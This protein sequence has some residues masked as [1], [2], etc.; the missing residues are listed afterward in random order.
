MKEEI[1]KEYVAS[2]IQSRMP[3]ILDIGCYDCKDS[4]EL[5]RLLSGEAKF[6]CFDPDPRSA[7]K[8]LEGV[9][10]AQ[11][12]NFDII[13]I[14]LSDTDGTK[15]LFMS[16]SDTR[17]HRPAQTEWSASSS[18]LR[19]KDHLDLF[20]DV[21]FKQTLEVTT[22]RLDTW[23]KERIYPRIIDLIWADVNGG[24]YDLIKGGY[25]TLDQRTR[26]L[27]IEVGERELYDGQIN[28]E[29]LLLLLPGFEVIGQYGFQGNF[30][31]LLL[32]NTRI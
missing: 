3:V 7:Q 16:D 21:E 2:L 17:R 19:P 26:Y 18:L 22:K 8:A 24:E 23:Y 29:F 14:A 30:G 32:K 4:I 25:K 28:K 5:S 9:F 13:P 15:T 11:S 20:P 10:N 27:Y 1:K 31:N 12:G 6:Y